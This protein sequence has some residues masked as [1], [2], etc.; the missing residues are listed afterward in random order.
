[1]D[2][3]ISRATLS[4]KQEDVIVEEEMKLWDLLGRIHNEVNRIANME[5]DAA[6]VGGVAATGLFQPRKDELI[7]KAEQILYK[8]EKIH[9]GQP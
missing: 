9:A 4:A 1:M 8:L 3:L 7:K 5:S 2:G 6:L